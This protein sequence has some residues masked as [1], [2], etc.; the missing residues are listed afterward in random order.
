[1]QRLGDIMIQNPAHP[2]IEEIDEWAY[3]EVEVPHQEWELFLI[4]KSDFAY[5]LKYASDVNCPK[6]GF[7]L[8]LLYH[9]VWRNIKHEVIESNLHEYR[10]LFVAAE[11]I[12]TPYVRIWLRRTKALMENNQAFTQEQWYLNR[13]PYDLVP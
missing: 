7:F 8:D 1:M 5:Y 11:K 9:W 2:T 3:S 6:E 12:N 4:W 13:R 10:K